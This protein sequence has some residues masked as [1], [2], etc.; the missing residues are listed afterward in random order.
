[1]CISF[2]SLLGSLR[3]RSIPRRRCSLRHL[4]QGSIYEQY[5]MEDLLP[6]LR[7]ARSELR[8]FAQPHINHRAIVVLTNGDT[9]SGTLEYRSSKNLIF[10]QKNSNTASA[11]YFSYV[12]FFKLQNLTL[13]HKSY[14]H[15][16]QQVLFTGDYS[17]IS[18]AITISYVSVLSITI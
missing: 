9:T 13:R 14:D 15:E 18:A 2:V 6:M 7:E 17:H 10:I 8:F 3:G 11:Y 5:R 1:M 4:R 16:A 12:R